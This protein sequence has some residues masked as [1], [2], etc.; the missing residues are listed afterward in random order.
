MTML[1]SQLQACESLIQEHRQMEK[2][3][4]E[5]GRALSGEALDAIRS[6]MAEITPDMNVHFACEEQVLFPA[7]SPYHSMVLMEAEHEELFAL[8]AKLEASVSLAESSGVPGSGLRGLGERFISDMLDHIGREDVGIFPACERSLSEAEKASVIAGMEQLRQAASH[9]PVVTP[10][11][12]LRT[13]DVL[14]VDLGS[15][16]ERPVFSERLLD[17]GALEIKHLVIKAGQALSS[18][19]SPKQMTLVCLSGNGTFLANQ[20]QVDLKPGISIVLDSKLLHG[21][22]AQS[23]CHFLLILQ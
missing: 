7:V 1:L 2:L 9:T 6:V 19:W 23:D 22:Q 8:R 20:Q 11:P 15:A 10:D 3:L 5:L 14:G 13:F 17:K 12:P 4:E 21:V 18:H 16:I